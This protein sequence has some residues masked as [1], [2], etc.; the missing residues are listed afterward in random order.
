VYGTQKTTRNLRSWLQSCTENTQ[1][2]KFQWV[3]LSTGRNKSVYKSF[4]LLIFGCSTQCM[5]KKMPLYF[6]QLIIWYVMFLA[7]C[8]FRA[9]ENISTC[10]SSKNIDFGCE[11]V[12]R[13]LPTT[14]MSPFAILVF[15][16]YL[17]AVISFSWSATWH[18]Y[19]LLLKDMD[20]VRYI[21]TGLTTHFPGMLAYVL[22]FEMPWLLLRMSP[23]SILSCYCDCDLLS[24]HSY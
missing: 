6:C 7:L 5:V 11:S 9:S 4:K 15:I 1:W 2:L 20:F 18:C 14:P 21:I 10:S 24:M 23:Y 19:M 17:K 22:L 13:L 3:E 16:L 8:T 12:Y